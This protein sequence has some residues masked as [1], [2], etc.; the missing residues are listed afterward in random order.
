MINAD[1]KIVSNPLPFVVHVDRV[2]AEARPHGAV[3]FA[4]VIALLIIAIV[5]TIPITVFVKRRRRK[6][7]PIC[8]CGE[9][10]SKKPE[11]EAKPDVK[12]GNG[13]LK[14]SINPSMIFDTATDLKT[15]A[16][17]ISLNSGHETIQDHQLRSLSQLHFQPSWLDPHYRDSHHLRLQKSLSN[18]TRQAI[19]EKF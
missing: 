3:I 1:G 7:K 4:G 2:A 9:S 15:S 14:G 12:T 5:L 13:G 18:G 10:S 17:E 11:A 19:N 6:G 8:M 16:S